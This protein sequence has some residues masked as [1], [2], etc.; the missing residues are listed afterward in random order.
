MADE[1]TLTINLTRRKLWIQGKAEI[2]GL[3]QI[4]ETYLPKGSDIG[5]FDTIADYIFWKKSRLFSLMLTKL[6]IEYDLYVKFLATL[7][8]SAQF[9]LSPE[10]LYSC[11]RLKRDGLLETI[12]IL[13]SGEKF[14]SLAAVMNVHIIYGNILNK[15]STACARSSL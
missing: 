5:E 1:T 7:Y 12:F 10:K 11:R 2:R 4:L 6:D 13:N 14:L 9:R 8:V 15:K 3:K